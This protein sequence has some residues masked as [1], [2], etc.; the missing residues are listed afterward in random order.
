MQSRTVAEVRTASVL[1]MTSATSERSRH[2]RIRP[3]PPEMRSVRSPVREATGG[4]RTWRSP[5]L[6]RSGRPAGAARDP[7]Y[8]PAVLLV[9]ED[10]AFDGHDPG[11][12]HPER[13]AR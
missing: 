5:F 2:G 9:A 4:E 7:G 11:P 10:R 1:T 12:G 13:V 8:P 3:Q 6:T